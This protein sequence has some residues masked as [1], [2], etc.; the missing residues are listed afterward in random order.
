MSNM[1]RSARSLNQSAYSVGTAASTGRI[2]RQNPA[3]KFHPFI[4]IAVVITIGMVIVGL[5]MT[6]IANWPGYSAIGFNVLEIVG[7]VI[8][9]VG[10]L[11][12]ILTV[13]VVV[14]RNKSSRDQWQQKMIDGE[15]TRAMWASR[16]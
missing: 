4:I 8:L 3:P 11:A 15:R 1:H 5:V 7:P 16:T 9:G 6:I 2:V 13:A 12:L 10:G 14:M